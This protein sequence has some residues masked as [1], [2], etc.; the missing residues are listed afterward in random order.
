MSENEISVAPPYELYVAMQQQDAEKIRFKIEFS[1]EAARLAFAPPVEGQPD[2]PQDSSEPDGAVT[3]SE[4]EDG[5]EKILSNITSSMAGFRSLIDLSGTMAKSVLG[6]LTSHKIRDFAESHLSLISSDDNAKVFGVPGHHT[7]AVMNL[8]DDRVNLISGFTF[9]PPAILMSMVSY[10]DSALS[11]ILRLFLKA[12]PA[13]YS[14]SEKPFLASELLKMSSFD[15]LLE[16]IVEDDI[17][18]LM[19]G[20]HAG[21]IVFVDKTF[22]SKIKDSFASW[23]EF[24]EI[25]ERRNIVAHG[26]GTTNEIYR[27]NCEDAGL[28]NIMPLGTEVFLTR[29]YLST[30]ANMLHEM[31]LVVIFELWDK[32][33]KSEKT[34]LYGAFNEAIFSLLKR[35]NYQL[36]NKIAKYV[37]D[38]NDF[39]A[40]EERRRMIAVNLAIASKML[41]KQSDADAALARFQWSAV[42]DNFKICIAAIK[43]DVPVVI[44]LMPIVMTSFHIG[45]TEFRTW[46]AFHWVRD[47]Q[48]VRSK[49]REIYNEPLVDDGRSPEEGLGEDGSS[50]SETTNALESRIESEIVSAD[51]G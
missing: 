34:K 14:K 38:K 36:S 44:Q 13:R 50:A 39:N 22:K 42:S 16:K 25:F 21:Q 20:G 23:P 8:F 30:S 1:E 19:R 47:N 10:Y 51:G 43:E 15:E 17:D 7:H 31:L 24:I 2:D 33:A 41:N 11:D 4:I 9:F 35:K 6:E 37:L 28:K 32:L 29:G 45:K 12:N 49:F 46:P 26:S 40:C 5:I 3:G 48:E 18:S 27:K